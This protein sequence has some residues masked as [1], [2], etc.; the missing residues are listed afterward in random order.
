M[1]RELI[2]SKEEHDIRVAMWEG[3]K[4]M[5]RRLPDHHV[6]AVD[7]RRTRNNLTA[8]VFTLVR[9][10]EPEQVVVF[11]DARGQLLPIQDFPRRDDGTQLSHEHLLYADDATGGDGDDGGGTLD[12]S[13]LVG[14]PTVGGGG[15][16]MP[17]GASVGGPPVKGP[18]SPG[19]VALGGSLLATAFGAGEFTAGA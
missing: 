5:A 8:A 10:G 19:V 18:V 6:L 13:S 7:L 16:V 17:D 14:G 1:F 11:G 3:Y 9:G 2:V 15:V 4:R 12:P